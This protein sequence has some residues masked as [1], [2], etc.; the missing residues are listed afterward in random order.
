M[1]KVMIGRFVA[2]RII[3]TDRQAH[4]KRRQNATE[5]MS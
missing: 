3:G 4:G 1:P 5:G 2:M